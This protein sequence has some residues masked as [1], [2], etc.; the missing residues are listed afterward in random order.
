MSAAECA[1]DNP[2]KPFLSFLAKHYGLENPIWQ[3]IRF[4]VFEQFFEN[5]KP[6]AEAA[7]FSS[8]LN[9]RASSRRSSFGK[10][11]VVSP[12]VIDIKSYLKLSII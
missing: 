7:G 4:V 6:Q 1:F 2:S 9:S 8:K 12:N 5:L 11:P 3:S 10:K